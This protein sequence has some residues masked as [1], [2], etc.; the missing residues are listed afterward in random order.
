MK[1]LTYDADESFGA[2]MTLFSEFTKSREEEGLMAVVSLARALGTLAYIT[3]D[4]DDRDIALSTLI[5]QLCN[6]FNKTAEAHN[7]F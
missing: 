5:E 7:A 3:S 1:E 4:E 6:T 2:A